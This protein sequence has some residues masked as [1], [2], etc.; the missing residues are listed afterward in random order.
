MIVC[1]LTNYLVIRAISSIFFISSG[2]KLFNEHELFTQFLRK[3]NEIVSSS[4]FNEFLSGNE[5]SKETFFI[6][7]QFDELFKKQSTVNFLSK[8]IDLVF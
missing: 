6:K 3:Q 1:M 8:N 4:H 7:I 5:I 2:Q